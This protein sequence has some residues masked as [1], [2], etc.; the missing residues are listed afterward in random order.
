VQSSIVTVIST[1]ADDEPIAEIVAAA[2]LPEMADFRFCFTGRSERW[3][4]SN[5]PVTATNIEF[6]GFVPDDAYWQQLYESRVIV[7]LT[8]RDACL[9]CG[10]YEALAVGRPMVLSDSQANRE[11]FEDTACFAKIQPRSISDAVTCASALFT[12]VSATSAAT[13]VK[14]LERWSVLANYF[15]QDVE[16]LRINTVTP[17]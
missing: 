7:D 16:S 11:L 2:K 12:K 17:S 10:A 6:L 9:V 14:Y 3:L 4:R 15:Q 1:F 5:R 13:K 8:T